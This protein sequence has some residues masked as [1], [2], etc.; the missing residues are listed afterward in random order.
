MLAHSHHMQLADAGTKNNIASPMKDVNQVVDNTL[1][2]L[3]ST[4]GTPRCRSKP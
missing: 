4:H 2:S 1:D 3:N